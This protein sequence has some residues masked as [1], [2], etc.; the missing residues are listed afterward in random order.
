MKEN[1]YNILMFLNL[2]THGMQLY[3]MVYNKKTEYTNIYR[4][5]AAN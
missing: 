4:T 1:A 3:Y 2:V 5:F